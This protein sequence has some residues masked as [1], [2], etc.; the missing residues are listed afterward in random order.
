MNT[1]YEKTINQIKK[2][3]DNANSMRIRAEAHLE[4]LYRQKQELMEELEELGVK[5]ENIKEE[6]E[7]L[8]NNIESMMKKANKLLP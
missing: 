4:Q 1:D 8:K 7:K 2:S 6:I 3:L 5:P